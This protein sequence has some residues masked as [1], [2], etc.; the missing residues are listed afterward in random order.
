MSPSRGK[1]EGGRR[2]K[3]PASRRAIWGW[4]GS[5]WGG[6]EKTGERRRKKKQIRFLYKKIAKNDS[7]DLPK[8]G[9]LRPGKGGKKY[10]FNRKGE[11]WS[12]MNLYWIGREREGKGLHTSPRGGRKG[13]QC[14]EERHAVTQT[15]LSKKGEKGRGC[16]FFVEKE[17]GG[18][19][20]PL[21]KKKR[22]RK[23]EHF[24]APKEENKLCPGKWRKKWEGAA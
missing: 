18:G 14:G 21:S 23:S 16:A 12:A 3:E 1:R 6:G 8:L 17:K 10:Y 13:K 24:F 15:F 11:K 7:A 9:K 19:S 22:E 20:S 2:E 4:M 5:Q